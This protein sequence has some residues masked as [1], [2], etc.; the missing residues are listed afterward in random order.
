MLL[1]AVQPAAP[2]SEV[3]FTTLGVDLWPDYDRPGVLIIYR[4]SVAPGVSLPTLVA[5]RIPA[6]AGPPNAVAERQA[7]GQLITLPFERRIEGDT[8]VIEMMV[9]RPIVQMEY[10]D[11]G[12]V[13]DGASRSFTYTW[14]GDYAV[15]AL[16]VSAQQPDLAQNL[17]TDPPA[18]NR[19]PGIDGLMYHTIDLTGLDAGETIDV[20]LTYE[21]ASDQLSVETM[22]PVDP[23]PAEVDAA[24]AGGTDTEVVVIVMAVLMVVALIAAAVVVLRSRGGATPAAHG[25]ARAPAP[26]AAAGAPKFCTQC[27]A[28]AG[29]ADRFCHQCGN[30]VR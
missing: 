16:S 15:G 24:P 20:R 19:A 5:L 1:S 3:V 6:A 17:T 18:T 29:G 14:P 13:K 8:A 4:A 27:G 2:Q 11:P 7:D 23:P 28:A 10:Y 21:K 26:S 9:T 22:A 25:A 30:A 12:I